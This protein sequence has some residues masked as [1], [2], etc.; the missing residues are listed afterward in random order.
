MNHRT[1][2]ISVGAQIAVDYDNDFGN[3][4]FCVMSMMP[5]FTSTE[6]AQVCDAYGYHAPRMKIYMCRMCISVLRGNSACVAD[7]S[8][9]RCH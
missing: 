1:Q 3:S 8:K 9:S 6:R 7:P 5:D 2:I 4:K